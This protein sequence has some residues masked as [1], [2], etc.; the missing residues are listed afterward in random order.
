MVV[1]AKLMSLMT[2]EANDGDVE[3]SEVPLKVNTGN[4][5]TAKLLK[6]RIKTKFCISVGDILRSAIQERTHK[7]RPQSTIQL[8]V[9]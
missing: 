8:C 9:H 3:E 1:S 7:W 2:K 6:R 4:A 5:L